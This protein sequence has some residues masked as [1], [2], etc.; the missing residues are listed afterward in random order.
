MQYE[1]AA[2]IRNPALNQ[3][4]ADIE[5]RRMKIYNELFYN[6]IE[7]FIANTYPVLKS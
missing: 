4:P 7:D 3:K 1:F 5:A 2:H 6:N